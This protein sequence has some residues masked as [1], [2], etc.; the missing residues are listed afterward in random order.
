MQDRLKE[1][2]SLPVVGNALEGS[3]RL[4]VM[5]EEHGA[6]PESTKVLLSEGTALKSRTEATGVRENLFYLFLAVFT[7][8]I[9]YLTRFQA[10]NHQ[11]S[12]QRAPAETQKK[13]LPYDLFV[14]M[15]SLNI[16][17]ILCECTAFTQP[18]FY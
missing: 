7:L 10:Q 16:F 15:F 13:Q 14:F 4:L 9:S 18:H 8:S 12:F 11:M 6:K 2:C 17:F 3:L 1:S 5:S